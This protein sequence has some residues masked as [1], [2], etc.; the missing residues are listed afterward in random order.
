MADNYINKIAIKNA[1]GD[2][3]SREIGIDE[4]HV[5]F[6]DG[7]SLKDKLDDLDDKFDNLDV[8]TSTTVGVVKPGTGLSVTADGSLNV[9]KEA[10][11]IAT[12]S[13]PG[14][15][16]PSTGLSLNSTDGT[17]TLGAHAV[18]TT[19]YGVGT[20]TNYGHLKITDTYKSAPANADGLALSAKAGNEMYAAAASWISV[21]KV[22]DPD[23]GEIQRITLWAGKHS[24]AAGGTQITTIDVVGG[25]GGGT[26]LPLDAPTVINSDYGD[27]Y[28]SLQ[29][30]DPA[31]KE[32]A[33]IAFGYW[34]GTKVV[35][36][37][38]SRPTGHNDPAAVLVVDSKV[39][40]KYSISPYVDN[41]DNDKE[42]YYGIFP[43]TN[44]NIYTENS[45][46]CFVDQ[47]TPGAIPPDP[48]TITEVKGGDTKATVNYTLPGTQTK[49]VIVYQSGRVPA[50]IND[51]VQVNIA[52]GTTSKEITGLTNDTTYHFVIYTYNEKNR[53]SSSNSMSAIPKEV[54]SMPWATATSEVIQSMLDAHYNGGDKVNTVWAIGDKR[55]VS[56]SAMSATGVGESHKAQ[57]VEY[58]IIDFDKDTLTTNI[59]S[60]TKAAVTFS[61]LN[62]L[63]ADSPT[64]ADSSNNTEYGYM[65][66]TNTNTT[67]WTNCA[68]RTWCNN[69]YYNALPADFKALVKSVQKKTSAGNQSTTINTTNDYIWLLAEWEIFGAK[70]YSVGQSEGEQYEWYKTAGNRN[71]KPKWNS[72]N[73]SCYWWERSPNA[74][75]ATYF[76]RVGSGGTAND[77]NAGTARG[78]AP[79]GCL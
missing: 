77:N 75:S 33:G 46:S 16:M 11:D 72:S 48:A 2:Y 55:T 14:T 70:S 40:N 79:C 63:S 7:E 66:S 52:N 58:V 69:T 65:N 34:A 28:V 59:G 45:E 39:R 42:Y 18:S 54:T 31:D 27:G 62:C 60:S 12:T 29:W 4:E 76:C 68:R 6:T 53:T 5:I 50:N 17:L 25:G 61:Q 15:V 35:R 67:G 26:N 43:Y 44:K 38:G 51:G 71:K 24:S 74:S 21:E 73:S 57:T 64:F 3:E 10:P 13:K 32:V 19:T 37:E 23:E 36:K 56:L 20:N 47:M 9:T 8:A 1:E 78:L 49:A 41:V 22:E 30:S